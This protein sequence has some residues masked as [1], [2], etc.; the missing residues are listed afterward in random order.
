MRLR[1]SILVGRALGTNM[2][3]AHRSRKCRRPL[4]PGAQCASE[5]PRLAEGR[6]D[7]IGAGYADEGDSRSVLGKARWGRHAS[8]FG[9]PVVTDSQA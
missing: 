4:A 9:S 5:P 1:S 8:S 7:D 6:R 2:K 3:S